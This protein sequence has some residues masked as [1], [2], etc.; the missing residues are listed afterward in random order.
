MP[1]LSL[2]ARL[3]VASVVATA[4]VLLA[5]AV[6]NYPVGRL[7]IVAILCVLHIV[8]EALYTKG[9]RGV[10]SISLGSVTSVAAIPLV[11]V[12]GAVVRFVPDVLDCQQLRA[13]IERLT[14]GGRCGTEQPQDNGERRE[15]ISA[16]ERS[17]ESCL[18]GIG[19]N[20]GFALRRWA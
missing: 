19:A 16:G 20:S 12:W 14:G 1:S 4:A 18:L 9:S 2:G 5:T 15:Q 13:E 8:S 3:Y 11:G 7:R 17:H 6:A 10:L